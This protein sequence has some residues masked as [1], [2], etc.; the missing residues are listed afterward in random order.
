MVALNKL[1]AVTVRQAPP[2]KYSDG[3]GLWLHKRPDGGGQW[4]LRLAVH[5]RRREMGLGSLRHVS[6]KEARQ[7]AEKWRAVAR[8]G[9]DPIKERERERLEAAKTR[10][11]L[12]AVADLAFEAR[13]AELKRDG[14]AGRWF[15]PI[16]LHV[17][18]RLGRT[19][20][21]E[22]DQRDIRATLA[23]IW[24]TKAETA[25]K[26]LNRLG[27]ILRYGAAMGLDVD[28]Q[29]TDKAKELLGRSRQATS[30]IPS[31]PWQEVPAFYASLGEGTIT[32]LALR[33][34]I[35]TGL[36]SSPIRHARAEDMAGDTW[37]VPAEHMK[38]RKD[39]VAEFRVPLSNEAQRVIAEALPF[40]RDGYLFP[41]RRSGVISDATMSR[42]MERRG[43]EARPHGFR[44]SLRTWLAEET[45]APHEVAETV[46]AHVAGTR[47]VKTYRRT[48][49]LDQRRV[50][51]QRWAEF[52]TGQSQTSETG[53][54]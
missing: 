5:G 44:S 54:P 16:E 21:E 32:H 51:M 26:A 4:V 19:P 36:R 46:I 22:I 53:D 35:L 10:H 52:V 31:M 42:L 23:P 29:A 7:Q 1:S 24:H 30:H 41:N 43:L 27:L 13:K 28:L 20:I 40:A 6:L 38:G 47:V 48:D 8:Q 33:L 49:Y 12:A 9:Q 50:L 37:I 3:D 18:P 17:L 14:T 45:D 11:T 39:K 34:L 15:S 2:G 25:R